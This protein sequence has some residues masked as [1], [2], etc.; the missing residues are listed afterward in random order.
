MRTLGWSHR[1]GG[2][3]DPWSSPGSIAQELSYLGISY[4]VISPSLSFP[5]SKTNLQ[6][7]NLRGVFWVFIEITHRRYSVWYLEYSRHPKNVAE[8]NVV[9]SQVLWRLCTSHPTIPTNIHK[10]V[11]ISSLTTLFLFFELHQLLNHFARIGMREAEYA[12]QVL[13]IIAI[14]GS[15]DVD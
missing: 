13:E 11:S 4:L 1:L 3:T 8:T 12:H 9:Q 14:Q 15:E 5:I 6:C 7:C 10:T 2:Q